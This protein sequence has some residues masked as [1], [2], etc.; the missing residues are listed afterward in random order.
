MRIVR[1][2]NE[3]G[4]AQWGEAVDKGHARPIPGDVFGARDV[5]GA[6]EQVI[7]RL[8]PVE[9]PN[10]IAIGRNYAEH[11]KEMKSESRTSE[12]LVF[13]KA[14][15]TVIGPEE[16]IVLPNSAPREVDFEAELAIV[17]GCRAKEISEQDALA[18]V[19]GFT[20]ANDVSARDCQKGDKQ[21]ARG[22]SFD[23]FCPLGPEVVTADALDASGLAIRSTLNG[24]VMQSGNTGDMIFSVPRLVSYLSFQFTLLPG[25]VILTGTP[26]GVGAARTPPVFLKDGDTITIEIEGIGRL[27][28]RVQAAR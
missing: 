28:N 3:A 25:T 23:T 9:P 17:I 13:L 5:G 2:V 14:T 4:A 27:T 15:T 16:P 1:Y 7:R 10:I 20:C 8:A 12:P 6:P 11:A 26:P 24:E 19:L 21:W 18:Y 22:K